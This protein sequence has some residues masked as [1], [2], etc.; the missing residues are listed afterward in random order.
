M[1]MEKTVPFTGV[2]PA[3]TDIQREA[4]SSG[5]PLQLRMIDGLPAF[6]DEVPEDG[7]QELRVSGSAGMMTLRRGDNA[8]AVVVWGNA[9]ADMVRESAVLIEAVRVAAGG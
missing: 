3:W 9:D 1:G 6:P 4:A 2:A 8:L 7:W 5:L